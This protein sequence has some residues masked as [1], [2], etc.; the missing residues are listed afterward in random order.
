MNA[1]IVLASLAIAIIGLVA[2]VIMKFA[3]IDYTIVSQIGLI[4]LGV[5]MLGIGFNQYQACL[6]LVS[7]LVVE[8]RTMNK[9]IDKITASAGLSITAIIALALALMLISSIINGAVI[10]VAWN[11]LVVP[12]FSMEAISFVQA[13]IVVIVLGIVGSFFRPSSNKE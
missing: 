6:V 3:G 8:Y 11:Y 4:A 7:V 10:Y 1:L 2:M 9:V 12:F 5:C 13:V